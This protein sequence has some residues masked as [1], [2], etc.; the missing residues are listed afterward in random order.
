LR[1]LKQEQQHFM[2]KTVAQK[3][4]PDFLLLHDNTKPHTTVCITHTITNFCWTVLP[5]APYSPGL[6]PPEYQQFVL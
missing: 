6:A 3:N 2:T 4:A 5:Y 1:K